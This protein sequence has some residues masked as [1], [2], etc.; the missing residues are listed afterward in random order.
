[1]N[2]FSYEQNQLLLQNLMRQANIADE[3]E[4]SVVSGVAELQL[5][6]LQR[7][8]I[9]KMSI[10]TIIKIARGLQISVDKLLA[11][12]IA[13]Y[14][15]DTA[16]TTPDVTKTSVTETF[17]KHEYQRLEAEIA[18][19]Q[20]SLTAEFQ[21]T[22]LQTIE[23]WL[24]QWPTAA[25][26]VKKNPQL[27]AERLLVLLQPI[28]QLLQKWGVETIS[29]VGEELPYDPQWHT[30]LKGM[31]EPGELVEVRYVGYKQGDKLL[32]KAKVSPI[33]NRSLNSTT[34]NS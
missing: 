15:T 12:F 18:R 8:L 5:F 25:A 30:L 9:A 10:A 11:T 26:A 16:V 32:H 20:A 1:M 4:L 33:D 19:Q 3:R 22:S 23:S 2:R 13:D 29:S 6:R 34:D 7:G 28:E 14:Q 24:L 21:Q 31:A 27:P 17:W